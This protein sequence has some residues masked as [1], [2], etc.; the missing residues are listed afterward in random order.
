MFF[1]S[2][3]DAAHARVIGH[4]VYREHVCGGSR[5]H[6]VGVRISTKIIETGHHRVLKSLID[7]IF[8]PKV[9]HS[10][11]DPLEIRDGD[12]SGVCQNVGNYKDSLAVKNLISRGRGWPIGAFGQDFALDPVSILRGDLV[13][14]RCR[15][16]HIALQ[17]QQLAIRD[18]FNS[19]KIFE[20][21]SWPADA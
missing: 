8:A 20:G 5:V 15:N 16:Q 1:P 14:G 6:R 17:F 10:V 7:Y 12:P 18:L 19:F 3:I 11:L 2:R 13:L 21:S 9:A 4:S